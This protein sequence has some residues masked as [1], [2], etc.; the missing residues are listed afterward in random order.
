V[1]AGQLNLYKVNVATNGTQFRSR[2]YFPW[3]AVLI[4]NHINKPEVNFRWRKDLSLEQRDKILFG[5]N[6]VNRE[7]KLAAKDIPEL[8]NNSVFVARSDT[9]GNLKLGIRHSEIK[10][11]FGV[12]EENPEV[13][14]YANG[15][16]LKATVVTNSFDKS[17]G[18][19]VVS[20][21]SSGRWTGADGKQLDPFAEIFTVGGRAR[22]LLAISDSYLKNGV[23]VHIIPAKL[24]YEAKEQLATG[25]KKLK[26]GEIIDAFLS[27][28][29]IE[30]IRY[31]GLQKVVAE[32]GAS[33]FLDNH[34]VVQ[35]F[36]GQVAYVS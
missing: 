19:T 11:A 6:I 2:D 29:L 33:N 13:I 36:G 5:L 35:K 27:T 28:G 20:G 1:K 22:D 25:G 10:E 8:L 3:L 18:T 12:D 4:G 17:D 14:V 24:F 30:G 26:D 7:E 34:S 23:A 31:E 16:V 9:H 21:G 32:K 15:R